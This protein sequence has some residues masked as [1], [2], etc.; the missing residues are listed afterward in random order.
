MPGQLRD[1]TNSDLLRAAEA[2]PFPLAVPMLWYL[3]KVWWF[4]RSLCSTVIAGVFHFMWRNTA[5]NSVI[6]WTWKK[7]AACLIILGKAV[8]V[9]LKL[10]FL[11]GEEK[12]VRKS[13]SLWLVLCLMFPR[14]ELKGNILVMVLQHLLFPWK[15]GNSGKCSVYV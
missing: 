10:G 11:Q 15:D 4:Y 8:D 5:R 7:I 6:Y 14:P 1:V 12:Q 3:Y 13:V 2:L 9:C